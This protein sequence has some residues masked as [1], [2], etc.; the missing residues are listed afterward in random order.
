MSSAPSL[1]L[2]LTFIRGLYPGACWSRAF[3]ENAG[4]SYVPESVI[5][6]TAAYMRESQVQP[7]AAYDASALA[8]R[9]IADGQRVCAEMIGAQTDEVLI[10]PSTTMNVYVLAQALGAMLKPGD[11]IIVATLDH[12]A[13]IGAWRRLAERGI[14]IREWAVNPETERLEP[15]ALDACLSDKTRLVCFSHCS[16]ILG[17]ANDVAAITRQA[18]G[19]GAMV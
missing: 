17:G 15:E 3:F 12:E 13:N 6:R 9:R 2:D 5:G 1:D 19:A 11:E 4:G 7:G 8:E 14:V 18:H 16:N 10:G